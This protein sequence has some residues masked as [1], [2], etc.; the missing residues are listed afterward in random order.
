[1]DART[2]TITWNIN[3]QKRTGCE[4]LYFNDNVISLISQPNKGSIKKT[5]TIK[6]KNNFILALKIGKKNPKN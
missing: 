1:M 6:S 5:I 3:T 2:N 4:N